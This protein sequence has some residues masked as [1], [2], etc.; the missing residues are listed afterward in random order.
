MPDWKLGTPL[1]EGMRDNP[2]LHYEFVDMDDIPEIDRSDLDKV[3]TSKGSRLRTWNRAKDDKGV[4]IK[5]NDEHWI[6]V[7]RGVGFHVDVGFPRYSYQLKLLVDPMTFILG[8]GGAEYPLM[9]GVFYVLDTHS[10]H[11][12]VVRDKD[13]EYNLSASIDSMPLLDIDQCRARLIDYAKTARVLD[14][15]AD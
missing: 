9:R 12:V 4:T 7:K 15:V 8:A 2:V 14:G 3:F 10:P 1:K 11:S 13:S 6:C 5:E